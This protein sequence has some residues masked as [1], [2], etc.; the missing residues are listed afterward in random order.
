MAQEEGAQRKWQESR[1]G[2]AAWRDGTPTPPLRRRRDFP[3]RRA[4][5]LLFP[6]IVFTSETVFFLNI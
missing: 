5:S 6:Q 3:L 4:R 2:R 1:K